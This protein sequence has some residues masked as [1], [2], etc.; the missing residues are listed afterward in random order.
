MRSE[1]C[2]WS[3]PLLGQKC[4]VL[5]NSRPCYCD[6]WQLKV[7][8]VNWVGHPAD[9]TY[10]IWCITFKTDW[11]KLLW[12]RSIHCDKLLTHDSESLAC[13]AVCLMAKLKPS[14][15]LTLS[16][17][18]ALSYYLFYV[19]LYTARYNFKKM[20]LRLVDTLFK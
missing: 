16:Y 8:A 5:H 10:D 18:R 15:H 2:L 3:R 14:K 19:S 20:K 17:L 9:V 6:F 4:W 7:L 13:K 12:M 1:Y 11:P